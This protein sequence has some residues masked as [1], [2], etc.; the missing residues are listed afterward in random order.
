MN[1]DRSELNAISYTII[2]AA[3]KVSRKLGI[4]FPEK[5]YER[6][7]CV[8]LRKA[9]LL[10]D[11]QRLFEVLYEGHVVG[12][13][14]PDLIVEDRVIVEVKAIATTLGAPHRSQGINY[15]RATGLPLCVLL[16]FGRPRLE[17]S[18]LILT[19]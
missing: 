4:G 14:I 12:E 15:L 10:I 9:E 19:P 18:R 6:A 13:F 7:L 3:Q 16:N 1:T 11:Q 17:Y 8:E 5:T 2:G